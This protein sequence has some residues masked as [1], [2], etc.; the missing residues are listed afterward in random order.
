MYLAIDLGG[1]YIKR[2][3]FEQGNW[4]AH[5]QIKTPA[6]KRELLALIS[7][8]AGRNGTKGIAVSSPGTVTK[9]GSIEGTSAIPYIHEGHLL[10]E[11][12]RA[13]G[14]AVSIENDACCAAL[15]EVWKGNGVGCK[16]V[17]VIVIGTGIGGALIKD[18]QL[19]RGFDL[20]GGELGYTLLSI[21]PVQRTAVPFSEMASA[22]A[23]ARRY[24]TWTGQ[25]GDRLTAS[26]VF[27]AYEA[28]DHAAKKAIDAFYFCLA[29]GIHN[30]HYVYNPEKILLGGGIS[31]RDDLLDGVRHAY[32]QLKDQLS[33]YTLHM[34]RFERCHFQGNANLIGAMHHFMQQQGRQWR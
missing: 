17:A 22:S 10:Q 31:A 25:P 1:T 19:H 14:L 18:G 27:A 21:D 13:T 34:P 23:I 11:I 32:M 26:D 12:E 3:F 9:H 4:F 2:A 16:D 15:A 7:S 6:T 33:D 28:G 20:L 24:A 30:V 8:W 29:A 5:E